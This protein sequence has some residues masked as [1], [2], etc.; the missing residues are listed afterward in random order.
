MQMKDAAV[1]RVFFALWPQASVQQALHAQAMEYQAQCAARVMRADT[2][3]MTLLFLGE[4]ERA[5][6]PQIMQ[7]AGKLTMSA[8]EITLDKLAFWPHHRIAYATSQVEIMAL[9]QL[10]MALRQALAAAGYALESREFV[11]HVTLLRHIGK[12][13]GAQVIP[14][15]LWRVDSFVLVASVSTGQGVGYQM[16]AQWPLLP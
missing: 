15:I 1:V 12:N 16:L 13:L 6:L 4:I 9:D 5:Q 14:P 2:L 8:F 7:N 10:V 3:H 11:P